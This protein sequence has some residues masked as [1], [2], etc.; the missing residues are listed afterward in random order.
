[1]SSAHRLYSDWSEHFRREWFGGKFERFGELCGPFLLDATPEFSAARRRVLFVGQETNGWYSV[2]DFLKMT[3]GLSEA[4]SWYRDFDFAYSHPAAR[5]PFWR[6]H[7]MLAQSLD[8]HWRA[9]LWSN[10]V[11]FDGKHLSR[12]GASI[13]GMPFENDL[14]T[15]QRGVLTR[16]IER[17]EIDTVVLVTGP[18][19][20]HAI[21]SEFGEVEFA[22]IAGWQARQM[23]EVKVRSLSSARMIRTYH[24]AYLQRASIFDDAADAIVRFCD[25]L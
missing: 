9:L 23:A 11:R 3:G 24:P 25:R 19:Y 22:I 16:E 6:F 2:S 1:M 5:S 18:D 20:D 13:L 8:L 15:L 14:L 7:R 10:L 21:R 17:L 12:S 4:V